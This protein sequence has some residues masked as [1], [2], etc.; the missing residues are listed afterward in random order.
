MFKIGNSVQNYSQ[1]LSQSYVHAKKRG[2]ENLVVYDS[3]W[4]FIKA[5]YDLQE[6]ENQVEL[7]NWISN[8]LN[9]QSRNISHSNDL[10]S[11]KDENVSILYL[12]PNNESNLTQTQEQYFNLVYLQNKFNHIMFRWSYNNQ[13]IHSQNSSSSNKSY[14]GNK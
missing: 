4:Q 9:F 11:L 8:I 10:S 2:D 14:L 6:E 13:L 1:K 7:T 5:K 3:V 12:F